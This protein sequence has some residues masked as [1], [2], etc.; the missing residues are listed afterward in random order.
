MTTVRWLA[1]VCVFSLTCAIAQ[2]KK[3]KDEETQTLQ[4]PRDLPAAVVGETRRL[5][6]HVTPL[7]SRGL[8]SQQIRDALKAMARDSSGERVL[9]IRAFV[10]GSGDLRRVRDLVSEIFADRKQPLP[11]LSLI[12]AGGLPLEGAQVVMEY[13]AAARKDLRPF[14]LVF[15]SARTAVSDNPQDPIPPLTG[16]SLAALGQTLKAAGSGPED[17]LRVTCFLSSLDQLDTSR[18]M[19]A[20]AFPKAALN[21]VQTE[22]APA[23]AL[24][25]CEAVAGLKA[26]TGTALTLSDAAGLPAEPGESQMALVGA[27]QV[28]LTGT[29]VSFG[30]EE[31]D[32]RLA[33]E[34]LERV[35][36]ECGAG[37]ESV[38]FTHYYP[39]S[40]G[41][42][43]Q[44]R[45]VRAEFFSPAHPPAGAMLLFESLPSMDA[46]FAMD[47][48]AVGKGKS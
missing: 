29:Q 43:A 15:L 7:S 5:A 4:E 13:I 45:K 17:V 14:G 2:R 32:A 24:A 47:V 27:P 36:R 22:R 48:V 42:A 44:V 46:G 1:L 41:I 35:L 37:P 3:K 30:Y 28:V 19:A 31:K 6:F 39:L 9:K 34:R 8:L 18:Q 38:A 16:R 26:D 11:A 20:E 21:F 12:Q 33:F 40:P 25:A 10:A 23:R